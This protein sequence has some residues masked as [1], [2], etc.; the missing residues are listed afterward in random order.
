MAP[1][2]AAWGGVG[3]TFP[4]AVRPVDG[5][6]M[7]RGLRVLATPGHTP[8]HVCVFDEDD[9]VLFTGDAIGSQA[10]RLTLGPA[11]FIADQQEAVRFLRRLVDLGADRMLFGHGNE[12]ASPAEALARFIELREAPF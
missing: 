1:S 5:D 10:G 11:P 4:I 6:T 3:D 2:A 12:V 8:G 9:A 7:I